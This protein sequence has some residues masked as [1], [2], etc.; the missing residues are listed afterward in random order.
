MSI[1]QEWQ[2]SVD[3]ATGG[4]LRG[5]ASATM[6]I[7]LDDTGPLPLLTSSAS[8]PIP[9][10]AATRFA[11]EATVG[12]LRPRFLSRRGS[13]AVPSNI[14][15][16]LALAGRTLTNW[17]GIEWPIVLADDLAGTHFA[18][19]YGE[20]VPFLQMHLAL[21][22]GSMG[23]STC[24][25]APGWGLEFDA[26]ATIALNDLDEG[27]TRPHAQLPLPTGRITSVAVV[28]DN[29]QRGWLRRDSIFTEALLRINNA[30][31][32]LIAAEP[33]D[34]GVWRRYD[35]SVTV[36]RVPHA[37]DALP[38]EPPRPAPHFT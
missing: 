18:G 30:S 26:N 5:P 35:E 25:A 36:L 29:T 21:D 12:L 32:L 4:V 6:T 11:F 1:G 22:E 2:T 34:E 15:R 28:V 8:A 19:P 7:T 16:G 37:A 17:S 14:A 24:Q 13:D 23:L 33:D 27:F 31:V 38:W 9:T 20:R 3:D 10:E